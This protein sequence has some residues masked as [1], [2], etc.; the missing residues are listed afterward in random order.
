MVTSDRDEIVPK[1]NIICQMFKLATPPS[2]L[3][4]III[5]PKDRINLLRRKLESVLPKERMEKE[6]WIFIFFETFQ[7]FYSNRRVCV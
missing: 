7:Q 6:E 4:R 5:F 2:D 3:H 1:I